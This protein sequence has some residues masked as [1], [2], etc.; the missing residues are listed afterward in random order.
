MLSFRVVRIPPGEAPEWVRRAWVGLVLPAD[1]PFRS[2]VILPK[3]GAVTGKYER[4]TVSATFSVMYRT[5]LPILRA[6]DPEAANWW[7]NFS[8]RGF[9]DDP[10]ALLIFSPEACEWVR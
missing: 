4:G 3:R 8:H 10:S 7:E 2:G 1:G 9:R 5:A 6:V